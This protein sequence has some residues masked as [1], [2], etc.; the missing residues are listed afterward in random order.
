MEQLLVTGVE[1]VVGAN[2]A[3]WLADKYRLAGISAVASVS[4]EGCETTIAAGDQVDWARHA[5][6]AIQPERILVCDALG[7]SPWNHANRP[8]AAGIA[9]ARTWVR[10]AAESNIPL[11]LVSSDAIF[12]GPWMFHSEA[13]T[14]FCPSAEARLLR[15]LEDEAQRVCPSALIVR[16]HA[17]GWS[18]I[19][20][21]FGWIE[22]I[23][24][25]LESDQPGLFDCIP[26]ATPILATDLACVLDQAWNS[27]LSGVYHVAGAE[28]T[29]PYGFV[30]VL[31]RVFELSRPHAAN[32]EAS[33]SL[34]RGF[35]RG[36]TSL[37]TR[38]IRRSLG[39]A[40]PLLVEGLERLRD[41]RNDGFDR[42]VC[43]SR[44]RVASKV[45]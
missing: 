27:G 16:T 8:I 39:F 26:H 22:G 13:S 31:S 44:G 3:A 18:P 35:G 32:L 2:L 15:Q 37:Q 25:T 24:S 34:S 5:L 14:T 40:P 41:Q 38:T 17:Y 7:D 30:R 28:R 12:T 20:R 1:T 45:A 42:R 10:L 4:I 11:T 33:D 43:A 36:E 21:G 6:R 23:L 19:G 9:A 29:N